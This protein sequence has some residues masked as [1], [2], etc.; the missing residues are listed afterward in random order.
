M[1][2]SG[3]LGPGSADSAQVHQHAKEEVLRG[4]GG[5]AAALRCLQAGGGEQ[6][7]GGEA[8]LQHHVP[9]QRGQGCSEGVQQSLGD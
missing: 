1:P 7:D 9:A 8:E 2:S 3:K 6:G 4:G 5:E